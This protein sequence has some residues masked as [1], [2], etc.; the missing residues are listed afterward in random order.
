MP[1]NQML[2]EISRSQ[3]SQ[4]IDSDQDFI[5]KQFN[6][7]SKSI[8]SDL[9]SMNS[10][11]MRQQQERLKEMKLN[12]PI[13][14]VNQSDLES[15]ES[16]VKSHITQNIQHQEI[17]NK[18]HKQLNNQVNN[19][20]DG[21][22]YENDHPKTFAEEL[23]EEQLILPNVND[24]YENTRAVETDVDEDTHFGQGVLLRDGTISHDTSSDPDNWKPNL[25]IANIIHIFLVISGVYC[26]FL[27]FRFFKMTM[28]LL[29]LDFSYYFVI[30]FLTE[31]DIYDAENIGHQLGVFFG[32]LI[33]GLF[34]S[35]LSYIYE[36]SQFLIIGVSISSMISVFIAQFFINFEESSDKIMILCIYL[37]CALIFTIAAYAAQHSTLIWGTVIVGSILATI[38]FGVLLNDFKSF[39]Q[40]EKLPN[41][42]YS[43]FVNYL[44]ANAILICL[45]L[46]V[47]F[48][49]K[50]KIIQRLRK[51]DEELDSDMYTVRATTFL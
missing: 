31:F 30:L 4:F 8:S 26:C 21:V 5:E 10:I 11:E 2:S 24:K 1:K 9:Q 38:N 7:H 12:T 50:K 36:K 16:S 22:N 27:G 14:S 45:G 44:I 34:V 43:D 47:Q 6:E 41:D 19:I 37:G 23:D 46:L 28:I 29:G 33:L 51:E 42:R 25:I 17:L 40:R 20:I 3:K 35:I 15:E 48:Y 39:E 49:L 18:L 32:S 13:Q